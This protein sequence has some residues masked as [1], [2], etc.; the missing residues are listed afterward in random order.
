LA[1]AGAGG[2]SG[3]LFERARSLLRV[4][5]SAAVTQVRLSPD[6]PGAS[7]EAIL[8]TAQRELNRHERR[9]LQKK[10]KRAKGLA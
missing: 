5:E 10:L 6:L 1:R 3:S 7:L 9:R 8:P 4:K 2:D